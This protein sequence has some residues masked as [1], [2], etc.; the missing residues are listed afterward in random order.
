MVGDAQIGKTSLMVKYIEGKFDEDYI[1]TLGKTLF[2]FFLLFCPSSM[3][4]FTKVETARASTNRGWFV[5]S[6]LSKKNRFSAPLRFLPL[7]I[8]SL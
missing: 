6:Q 5:S 2:S 8:L 1:Q 3:E 4:I 7:F